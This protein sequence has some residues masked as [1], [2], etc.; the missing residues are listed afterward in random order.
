MVA[1]TRKFDTIVIGG[2]L[3]GL[4]AAALLGSANQKVVVLEKRTAVGGRGASHKLEGGFIFNQGPHALYND[5]KAKPVLSKLGLKMTGSYPAD[6]LNL[7]L[8]GKIAS[9][10]GNVFA[11]LINN[12]FSFKARIELIT[13]LA[14]LTGIKCDTIQNVDFESWV[15]KR[16][17]HEEVRKFIHSLARVSTYAES[18]N[19]MSAGAVVT[20]LKHALKGVTYLDGGW[21]ILVDQLQQLCKRKGVEIIEG[22]HVE[23]VATSDGE[24]RSTEVI[25]STGEKLSSS[26]LIVAVAPSAARQLL[27]HSKYLEQLASE[28]I[29]IKAACLD[30][31]L[32]KLPNEKLKFVFNLDEPIY[33]SVHSAYSKVTESGV[34]LYVMK[35]LTPSESDAASGSLKA[36]LE[37]YMDKNQPG[38]R[39]FVVH[40]RFL[41]SMIVSNRL[42]DYRRGGLAGRAKVRVPDL[43]NVYLAGDWVGNEGMLLDAAVASASEAV[44]QI[45]EA[46]ASTRKPIQQVGCASAV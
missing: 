44:E 21:Q 18:M 42:D 28:F 37:A 11:I 33:Y 46:Q 26:N 7:Q 4:T 9:L 32:T 38:W 41:P 39:E 29:P 10:P 27:E 23:S 45:L 40:E 17:R 3:A 22:A 35:Y 36:E 34:L 6:A 13:F 8:N 43:N 16:I 1:Q 31:A 24:N 20:Q 25:L 2:G 12:A 15:N 14:G 30:L 5:G 19:L